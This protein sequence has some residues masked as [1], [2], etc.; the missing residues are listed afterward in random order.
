MSDSI[1]HGD[2]RLK[3]LRAK[4]DRMRKTGTDVERDT[5]SPADE[6][7]RAIQRRQRAAAGPTPSERI[8]YRRDV[9]RQSPP[10]HRLLSRPAAKVTLEQ[11]VDG[12]E[13]VH[14]EWGKS[15]LI[16]SRV[17][18][19]DAGDSVSSRFRD[20]IASAGS[21]V[22]SRIAAAGGPEA[23]QPEDVIFMDIET[24]GLGNSPLFLIGAMAWEGSGF[25]VRQY[26]AR[27]YAEEAAVISFFLESCEAKRLL[28]TFNGKSFDV[29]F[30]RTRAIANGI[31][32]GLDTAHLDLLHVCRRIWK[33]DLPDCRLQTLE[34][35]ICGRARHGDIPGE[36]IP[37]AYHA[38]V[39]SE[40]AWQIVE[41]LNHNML[42][43]ITLADLM[44]R[45][46]EG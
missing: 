30:I 27:N 3:E 13:T 22:C 33:D 16:C 11:A 21:S 12:E 32:F 20:R 8:V 14:P 26:L 7:R 24:T 6:V 29:P 15:L 40:N 19:A 43:L 38:F 2:S 17:D 35:F 46:P 31:P 1:R 45:F 25:T 39:R 18:D 10:P 36:Q 4:L 44:T 9:P 34:R 37:E 42:D 28:V 23:L 41:I 5:W